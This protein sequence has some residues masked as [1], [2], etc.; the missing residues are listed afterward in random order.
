MP[1]RASSLFLPDFQGSQCRVCDFVSMPLQAPSIFLPAHHLF[2][3]L[4]Q[5]HG[6]IHPFFHTTANGKEF[7]FTYVC[8]CPLLDFFFFLHNVFSKITANFGYPCLCE[9]LPFFYSTTG[10]RCPRNNALCV[11]ALAGFVPFS[12]KILSIGQKMTTSCQCPIGLHPF[13]YNLRSLVKLLDGY[14]SMPYR[15]SSLF[16][17]KVIITELAE[18]GCVNALSGFVPFSTIRICLQGKAKCN[19]CQCPIGLRPFFYAKWKEFI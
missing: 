7:V 9:L 11:N 18:V 3:N 12:T 14:V 6:R 2:Y 4:C 10:I 1:L 17:H 16:L 8:Q 13:F 5:S 15:A 19:M